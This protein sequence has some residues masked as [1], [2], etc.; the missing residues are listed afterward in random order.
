MI[1]KDYGWIKRTMEGVHHQ[2]CLWGKVS[3][4]LRDTTAQAN[5]FRMFN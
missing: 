5:G 1:P 2:T 3:M 4:M